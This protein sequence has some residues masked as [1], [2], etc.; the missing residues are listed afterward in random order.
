MLLILGK[1]YILYFFYVY[2]AY[3]FIQVLIES[4]RIEGTLIRE[5]KNLVVKCVV[6]KDRYIDW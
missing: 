4:F 6:R 5:T 3:F 2:L 1:L